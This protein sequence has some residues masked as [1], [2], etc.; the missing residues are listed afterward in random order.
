MSITGVTYHFE[1]IRLARK[2]EEVSDEKEWTFYATPE[3][4]PAWMEDSNKV[5][6]LRLKVC[7]EFELVI[8]SVAAKWLMWHQL[9][10]MLS[11][12]GAISQ[13]SIKWL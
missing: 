7:T 9:T 4:R 8:V 11:M 13:S 2:K 5:C 6:A 10:L 3:G 12:S 1:A